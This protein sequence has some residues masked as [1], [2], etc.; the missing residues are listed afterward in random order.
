M[1]RTISVDEC[2]NLSKAP[3]IHRCCNSEHLL[4]RAAKTFEDMPAK[5]CFARQVNRP[6]SLP[7]DLNQTD[8]VN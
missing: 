1:P 3:I 2:D 5:A 6:S 7:T 8:K 4:H